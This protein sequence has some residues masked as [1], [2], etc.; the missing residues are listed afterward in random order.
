MTAENKG[1]YRSILTMAWPVMLEEGLQTA[2]SYVDAA[3]VGRLGAYAS[4]AVGINQTPQWLLWGLLRAVSIGLLAYV[5]QAVGAGNW[6]RVR[7][8]GGQALLLTL[9]SSIGLGVPLCLLARQIPAWMGADAGIRGV[10]GEYLLIL[11]LPI[12]FRGAT[13]IFGAVLRG[14]GDMRTPMLVNLLVNLINVVLNYFMIYKTRTISL[15][16]MR[17]RMFGCG[18][19]V[20]GA[21]IAS[22]IS[23]AVGGVLMVWA[24][25]RR[26]ALGLHGTSLRPDGEVLRFV[27]RVAVPAAAQHLVICSAFIVFVSL[28]T[29]LG[30]TALAAHSIAN[31]AEEAFYIPA[32]GLQAVASTMAGMAVG[33][34]D[35]RRLDRVAAVLSRIAF[36]ALAVLAVLLFFLPEQMMGIFTRD[37]EVIR[38]GAG[39]L[40][41]IALSEP[42]FGVLTVAEGLFRGVG[43]MKAPLYI[44]LVCMWGI[45]V[46]G[47]FICLHFFRLGLN[48]VWTC[49][50]ADNVTR[51]ALFVIRIRSGRWKR[52]LDL[53]PAEGV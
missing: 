35:E 7:R 46:L 49:M 21:A 24:F 38:Q 11:S 27:R 47:T 32:Y 31:T 41:I 14:T 40:R 18:W 8:A 29:T 45:C 37:P 39:A 42:I 1:F 48:A 16:G 26:S 22:A 5:A 17:M 33:A 23:I 2:V 4:A 36:G 6:D 10:A 43:D 51:C 12:L 34:R 52:G 13:I 53:R 9:V 28:V 20:R 25:G 44:S 19:G 50:L 15:F 3:M 30:T